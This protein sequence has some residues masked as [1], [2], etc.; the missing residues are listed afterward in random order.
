MGHQPSF[1]SKKLLKIISQKNLINMVQGANRVF[2]ETL[3]SCNIL[4]YRELQAILPNDI[5]HEMSVN[6]LK[7]KKYK[8]RGIQKNENVLI[9]I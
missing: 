5:Q 4:C 1:S 7:F 6:S 3:Y 2:K 8:D 9:Y